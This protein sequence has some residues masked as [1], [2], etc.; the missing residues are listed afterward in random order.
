MDVWFSS[1]KILQ[2][3]DSG[4]FGESGSSASAPAPPQ[5]QRC[6]RDEITSI[7]TFRA[8][9]ESQS[10]D[11]ASL[12]HQTSHVSGESEEENL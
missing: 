10:Q 6:Q 8:I 12:K 4:H 5:Q 9:L 1:L 2:P 3:H 7:E 11:D